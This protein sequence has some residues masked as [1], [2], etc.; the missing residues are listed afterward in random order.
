MRLPSARLT[1]GE[2]T[3][4]GDDMK[5]VT[6][7]LANIMGL[8]LLTNVSSATEV[9]PQ[10][11]ELFDDLHPLIKDGLRIIDEGAE[12]EDFDTVAIIPDDSD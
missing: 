2:R 12:S 10:V 5:K 3:C 9:P 4:N 1:V 11:A 8:Q 6:I 7:R